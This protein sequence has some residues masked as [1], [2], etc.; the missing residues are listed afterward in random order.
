MTIHP[1]RIGVERTSVPN[2]G[3]QGLATLVAACGNDGTAGAGTHA[4]TETVNA[5]TTTVVG[6]E[7][8]LALGHGTSL[9]NF[10]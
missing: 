7:S 10:R 1:K 4:G 8:T 9:L 3:S 5:C 2:L 6:L